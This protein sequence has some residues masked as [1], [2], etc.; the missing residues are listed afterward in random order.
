MITQLMVAALTLAAPARTDTIVPVDQDTRLEVEN[1]RGEVV[2]RAWGRDQVSVEADLDRDEGLDVVR[3]GTVLRVRPRRSGGIEEADFVI[4]VPRWMDVRVEGNQV[5]VEITGTQGEVSVETIGGDVVVQGGAG[6]IRLRSIQGEIDLRDARGR[7]EAV[8]VNE[9]VTLSD[10]EG[11]IY[12]ETTNG[13]ISIENVRSGSTRATTVNGDIDY[14]G[15][16]EGDG[17]YVFATHNGDLSVTVPENANATVSVSTY[18]GEFESDF[19]VR[20][21]GTT[22][23]RQFNFTLGSGS[24]RVELESFNGEIMLRRP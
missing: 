8:S 12:V 6:L 4:S 2:V 7:V 17:H 21:T 22:R 14:A 19:P 3:T 24:A 10:V 9:E 16:I 5:D 11:E 23:D 13:D 18:H 1:F 20:L 15:S